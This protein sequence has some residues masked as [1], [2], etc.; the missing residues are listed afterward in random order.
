MS[1]RV[2]T[3]RSYTNF[4]NMKNQEEIDLDPDNPLDAAIMGANIRLSRSATTYQDLGNAI[5][6]RNVIKVVDKSKMQSTPV[7]KKE[8][9]VLVD[10]SGKEFR[11]SDVNKVQIFM[12]N[13]MTVDR[14]ET[15]DVTG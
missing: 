6:M 15:E 5:A 12:N 14:I 3:G 11:T 8:Y 9:T 7:G 2:N 10:A 1:E 4:V 13:G